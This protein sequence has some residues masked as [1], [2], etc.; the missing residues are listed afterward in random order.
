MSSSLYGSVCRVEFAS[1]SVRVYTMT[2]ERRTVTVNGVECVTVREAARLSGVG[3]SRIRQLIT[4]G[5]FSRK[6]RVGRAWL[7][8][9]ADVQRWAHV[10]W[11]RHRRRKPEPEPPAVE[12]LSLDVDVGD[13]SSLQGAVDLGL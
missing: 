8:P 1:A 5:A 6:V 11:K 9:L 13:T 2:N 12:Q 10:G 7:L 3:P 4:E